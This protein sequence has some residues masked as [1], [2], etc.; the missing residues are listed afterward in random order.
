MAC[1]GALTSIIMT[2]AGAFIANGGLSEI[3]GAAPTRSAAG[4]V[5]AETVVSA[6][7][8]SMT[9]AAN[10]VSGAVATTNTSWFSELSTTLSSMKDSVL[11]F[12]APMREA[13]SN[14]ANAPVAAGILCV[15]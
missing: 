13:W 14:I 4:A 9:T 10:T 5:G 3:F 7:G 15:G 11:E 2:A 1:S 8:S 6:G 12:T